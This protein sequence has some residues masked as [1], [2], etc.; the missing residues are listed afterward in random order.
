MLN[1]NLP[2]REKPMRTKPWLLKLGLMILCGALLLGSALGDDGFYVISASSGTF[3]GNW[4][5]STVYSGKDIVFFNGSSWFSLVGANTGHAPDV[6]PSQWTMLCQKGDKGTTGSTGSQ[7]PQG[8]P[9]TTGATGAQ[10]QQGIPGTPG[11][12]GQQGIPGPQGIQGIQGPAGAS[13]WGLNGANTYY[14]QG[15][16]GIGTSSPSYPFTIDS[17]AQTPMYASSSAQNATVIQAT[18]TATSGA[19]WGVFGL[20]SSTDTNACG[21]RGAAG[22]GA[23]GVFGY[24]WGYGS[25][26]YGESTAN[27]SGVRGKSAASNGVF[28]ETSSTNRLDAGVYGVSHISAAGVYGKNDTAEELNWVYGVVGEVP[29]AVYGIGVVGN[30]LGIYG[31]GVVGTGATSGVS[32]ICT[33]NSVGGTGVEGQASMYGV[34]VLGLNYNINGYG[35]YS[36]GN[37]AVEPG[38]TKSAIVTTSQGNRKLYSQESPEVWFEDVG[39]GQLAGG[40]A[41]IDLDQL[42]LETVTVDDQHPLKVFIQLNDNCNGV[43]VQRQATAFEV[44]ELNGGNSSAHFTYRVMAKRKGFENERLAAAPDAPKAAPVRAPVK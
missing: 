27:G 33:S 44:V 4:D 28:G 31:Y 35:V 26:V 43:Y 36:H 22:G 11:A 15:N 42:F 39:E 34:G 13:P 5:V 18:S 7:G 23:S 10:G 17:S 9:G 32:G 37:F 14:T 6:S 12:T 2:G 24:G 3:K 1:T 40:L 41:H 29:N 20:T 16:V 21:V 25:G 30:S 38:F 8:V 19:G